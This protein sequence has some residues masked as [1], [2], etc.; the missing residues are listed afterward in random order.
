[1]CDVMKRVRRFLT[2]STAVPSADDR[3]T[4]YLEYQAM[5]LDPVRHIP[6]DNVSVAQS[7][8]AGFQRLAL[9]DLILRV[10]PYE[11][12]VFILYSKVIPG[13]DAVVELTDGDRMIVRYPPQSILPFSDSDSDSSSDESDQRPFEPQVGCP[14]Y[15]NF[16]PPVPTP[17]P[18][19]EA[20]PLKN[21]FSITLNS[22]GERY[23]QGNYCPSGTQSQA[24]PRQKSSS[25]H[26]P[27]FR[28][29]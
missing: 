28:C 17:Q 2:A 9:N 3:L 27:G 13:F 4:A 6:L 8:L 29:N 10:K 18:P 15:D 23:K 1:M 7:K 20:Q 25:G 26:A 11:M 22:S 14:E 12:F 21:P 24:E 19:T 16:E 5:L